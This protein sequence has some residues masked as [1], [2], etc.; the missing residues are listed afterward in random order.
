MRNSATAKAVA[1]QPKAAAAKR[2]TRKRPNVAGGLSAANKGGPGPSESE[3]SA[4]VG[5]ESSGSFGARGKGRKRRRKGEAAAIATGGENRPVASGTQADVGRVEEAAFGTGELAGAKRPC[6]RRKRVGFVG[7]GESEPEEE[8]KVLGRTSELE[9]VAAERTSEGGHAAAPAASEGGHVATTDAHVAVAPTEGDT[10]PNVTGF[11]G[12]DSAEDDL[13]ATGVEGGSRVPVGQ[14]LEAAQKQ[15]KEVSAEP[16]GERDALKEDTPAAESG[17]FLPAYQRRHK[18]LRGEEKSANGGGDAGASHGA[19]MLKDG[20]ISDEVEIGDRQIADVATPATEGNKKQEELESAA[21]HARDAAIE[22]ETMALI[23]SV[24]VPAASV[25]VPAESVGRKRKTDGVQRRRT[26]KLPDGSPPVKKRRSF[27]SPAVLSKVRT[28]PCSPEGKQGLASIVL[29]GPVLDGVDT[30]ETVPKRKRLGKRRSSLD[31]VANGKVAKEKNSSKGPVLAAVG[32]D[33][34]GKAPAKG[35]PGSSKALLL[36]EEV[37][38]QFEED[39]GFMSAIA[40]LA[41]STKRP[42]I[43]TCNGKNRK[44]RFSSL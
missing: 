27:G 16:N 40:T 32:V 42:M 35:G 10:T 26:G 4:F 21:G 39:K 18:G 30:P 22:G 1:H 24:G 43:L 28:R 5:S 37:E 3:I 13:P 34:G 15:V 23:P 33:A 31:K 20:V 29:E 2:N 14:D 44:S 11:A 7:L 9:H 12:P 25:G 17:E 36:F 41:A 38:Q 19:D 6:K 8:G